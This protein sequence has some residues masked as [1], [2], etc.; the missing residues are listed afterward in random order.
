MNK[1]TSLLACCVAAGFA[2]L[3]MAAEPGCGDSG[4]ALQVLGSGG[5]ELDDRRASASYLIWQD[6]K[7]RALVDFGSGA[8]LHFEQAGARL[9]DLEVLLFTHFHVDHAND[10]PALVKGSYFTGR[11]RDLPLYGPRGNELVPGAAAFLQALFGA[12][13]AYRYLGDYLDGSGSYR[14]QATEFETGGEQRIEVGEV[15]GLKLSAVPVHHGPIPALAWRVEIADKT[16]VFSG[17]LS[18]SKGTLAGLAEGADLLVVHNAIPE[19][20]RGAARN[21]HLPPSEIG[22]VAAQANAGQLVLSHFMLR[23]LDRED[24][25]LSHLREHY[26]GPVHFAADLRCF[27]P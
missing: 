5:P 23:T 1:I 20:A 27:E 24:E 12:Q 4:V 11:S 25:T 7:A 18:N 10:L 19:D 26:D 21:L 22:R 16:L 8:A 3:S 13:G 2:S 6:G 14:L 17:D 9:E 15:A